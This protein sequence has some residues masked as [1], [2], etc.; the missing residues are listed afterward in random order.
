MTAF[1][2][3]ILDRQLQGA[4]D[5]D[6]GLLTMSSPTSVIGANVDT[7]SNTVPFGFSFEFDG[8]AYTQG[9]VYTDGWMKL[10]GTFSNPYQNDQFDDSSDVIGL[11]PWWGDL[12]TAASGGYVAYEQFG[13]APDRY[14]VIEWLTY[15]Y[16]NHN[17]TNNRTLNFQ[18]VLRETTNN[19]EFRYGAPTTSGSPASGDGVIGARIDTT[20][21]INGNLREFTGK[22]GTLDANGGV[23]TTPVE[24]ALSWAAG[25]DF[26]GDPSNGF[27]GAAF[28]FH[29]LA[30]AGTGM[31]GAS[32]PDRET[33]SVTFSSAPDSSTVEDVA[34]WTLE[35]IDGGAEVVI[36]GASVDG[37]GTGVT[38]DVIGGLTPGRSYRV[39]AVNAA[40]GAV[41]A[42]PNV[43]TFVVPTS[44]VLSTDG[45][46]PDWTF[47]PFIL[48]TL[49]RIFGQEAQTLNGAPFTKTTADLGASDTTL[50]VESTFALPD[51]GDL[52]VGGLLLSYTSKLDTAVLGVTS[53]HARV[54]SIPAGTSVLLRSSTI[55]PEA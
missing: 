27:E 51:Q 54:T 31:T 18:L 29:F 34:D 14:V 20:G 38:L 16:F 28:N 42:S 23:S 47:D 37:A 12:R 2:D 41:A 11:F 39:T 7:G 40:V 55:E 19:V 26:P 22:S 17:T 6:G 13:T 1:A 45:F 50:Q 43:L 15:G 21:T 35:A 3:Y 9:T 32:A 25:A 4:P 30:T 48:E 52:W 46:A 36:T 53:E 44:L 5:N 10:A 33:V 24:L 49:T 8:V